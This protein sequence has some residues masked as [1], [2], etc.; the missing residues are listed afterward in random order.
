MG[1]LPFDYSRCA[2]EGCA[3]A[4]TCRR[5]EPGHPTYQAFSLFPGGNACRAYI[6][7]ETRHE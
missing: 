6:P 2:T 5:K 4:A 3:L 1:D 7:K